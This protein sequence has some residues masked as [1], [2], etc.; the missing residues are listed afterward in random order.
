M[1]EEWKQIMSSTWIKIVLA[2]IVVIPML[3]AG[4]F[5]G[6]MWD[7]YGNADKIPVA[8]VNEDHTV[9]YNGSKLHI[10]D[11][12]VSNLKKA[13]EMDFQF[14]DTKQAE[15]GLKDGSYYMIITIP[16]NF[17]ANATTLLEEQPKKM[18]LKYT[19][20]PGTNYIASKMDE[21]AISKIRE[22]ISATVTKSYADTLFS[23]VKVLSS[24]LKTAGQGS[25]KIQNGLSDSI[26]GNRTITENLN[27]LA[28]SSLT[29]RDGSEAVQNG[30]LAY[31]NGVASLQKGTQQLRSGVRTMDGK[32][33]V[34]VSGVAAMDTGSDELRQGV[35]AY[36]AGVAAL[37]QGSGQLMENSNALNQA[38]MLLRRAPQ[39]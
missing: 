9:S 14:V 35:Q 26:S 24:G 7:P 6:S 32:S 37:Q 13:K 20:N 19:T 8:V 4:I 18:E 36:T 31:T 10:G 15:Q 5:L 34:L 17:S 39:I 33:A 23:N 2:A 11:D 27:T 30:L 28:S 25:Q 38:S 29:F 21:T 3:Y 12:L 16:K 1:K 22:Q